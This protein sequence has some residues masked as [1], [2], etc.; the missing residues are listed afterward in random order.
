[1]LALHSRWA[2]LIFIYSLV[3]L[4]AFVHLEA[5]WIAR[6]FSPEVCRHWNSFFPGL[7]SMPFFVS[8]PILAAVFVMSSMVLSWSFNI[9]KLP[10]QLDKCVDKAPIRFHLLQS[11]ICALQLLLKGRWKL[12]LLVRYAASLS[13]ELTHFTPRLLLRDISQD[14]VR[15][16][17]PGW[18]YEIAFAVDGRR[19][20]LNKNDNIWRKALASLCLS[21]ALI[22]ELSSGT[23]TSSH[24]WNGME[25]NADEKMQVI[26]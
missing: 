23:Q 6:W 11:C 8:L 13:I 9:P 14:S 25:E 20:L 21:D 2:E 26:C 5:I 3:S 1:M 4:L 12:T 16:F 17:I 18:R 7:G 22:P 15:C 24:V 10:I 19:R